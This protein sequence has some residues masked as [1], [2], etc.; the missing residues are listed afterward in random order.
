MLERNHLLPSGSFRAGGL[1]ISV[2]RVPSGS[3]R[4]PPWAFDFRYAFGVFSDAPPNNNLTLIYRFFA[5]NTC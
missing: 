5:L 4:T 3:G 2:P 1:L